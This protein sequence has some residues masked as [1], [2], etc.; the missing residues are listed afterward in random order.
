MRLTLASRSCCF[1]CRPECTFWLVNLPYNLPGKSF[2]RI[3]NARLA[4]HSVVTPTIVCGAAGVEEASKE[5]IRTAQSARLNWQ[6]TAIEQKRTRCV[7][8][9]EL[10]RFWKNVDLLTIAAEIE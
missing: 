6:S 1:A 7:L 9:F 8:L 4:R 2:T 3:Q 10:V 5:S